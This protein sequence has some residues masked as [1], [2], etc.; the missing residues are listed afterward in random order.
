MSDYGD[1]NDYGDF[2]D[3][4]EQSFGDDGHDDYYEPEY[5]DQDSGDIAANDDDQEQS[6]GGGRDDYYE[7]E[8]E[9]QD[10]GD[11][12]IHEGL[13][14]LTLEDGA[15]ADDSHGHVDAIIMGHQVVEC[16]NEDDTCA[17]GDG[18]GHY[19]DKYGDDYDDDDEGNDDDDDEGNDD[20]D[21]GDGYGDDEGDGYE[22]NEGDGYGDD[23]ED[24]NYGDENYHDYGDA[25]VY[26]PAGAGFNELG[27][28]PPTRYLEERVTETTRVRIPNPDLQRP[29]PT[30]IERTTVIER[31]GNYYDGLEL[32]GGDYHQPISHDYV[33]GA[34]GG[35]GG[36][37]PI[38]GG[39]YDGASYQEER[40]AQDTRIRIP[41]PA[42]Q[43]PGPTRIDRR[44]YVEQSNDYD[45]LG[46]GRGYEEQ[47]IVDS[48]RVRI[49]NPALQR[50]QPTTMERQ[51]VRE[52]RRYNYH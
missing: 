20:D 51:V 23:D 26:Q 35:C 45:A 27:G 21:E 47:R 10:G 40:M 25:S 42:L 29:G 8:Y 2:D 3:Y 15:S 36:Y 12:D 11:G 5:E 50:P 6:F 18:Y 44:T 19:G 17:Q 32:Y 33:G 9:D 14:N 49:P 13:E 41:N 39:G 30:R 34:A 7:P 46:G 43:R 1:D 4:Q 16:F 31:S 52:T 22:D 38:G 37:R 24:D 48:S 28:A